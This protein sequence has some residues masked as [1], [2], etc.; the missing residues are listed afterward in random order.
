MAR[1]DIPNPI[2]LSF[3][4]LLS[5]TLAGILILYLLADSSQ[6]THEVKQHPIEYISVKAGP[7]KQNLYIGIAISI[8]GEVFK[9]YDARYSNDSLIWTVNPGETSVVIK[10]E[11]KS[12]DN[13][14]VLILGT[15][16]NTIVEG[17]ITVYLTSIKQQFKNDKIQLDK[18]KLYRSSDEVI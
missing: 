7:D 1:N 6:V 5:C 4:D 10:K 12:I 16:D 3:L 15:S 11:I 2:G 14:S 9:S 17:N 8:D 13:F 18:N